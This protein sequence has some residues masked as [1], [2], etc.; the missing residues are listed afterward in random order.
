[1][2]A[3]QWDLVVRAV[4]M[5]GAPDLAD[6]GVVGDRITH[7]QSH[8]DGTAGFEIDGQGRVAIPGLVEPHLHLD[9]ALLAQ[10]APNRSGTL[11]EAIQVTAQL[12]G[13]TPPRIRCDAPKRPCACRSDAVRPPSAPRRS[14]TR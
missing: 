5:P 1:M 10:R 3:S 7:I 12:K 11:E 13:S 14:S 9:K 4:R 8:L 6:I 2:D